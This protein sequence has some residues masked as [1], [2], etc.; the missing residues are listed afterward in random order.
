MYIQY[1][2]L[3][4]VFYKLIVSKPQCNLS[5]RKCLHTGRQKSIVCKEGW[6]NYTY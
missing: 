1:E 2:F 4:F 3:S 6:I 5:R